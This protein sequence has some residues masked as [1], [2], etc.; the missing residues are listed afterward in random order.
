LTPSLEP[1]SPEAMQTVIP[2]RR[3]LEGLIHRRHG[4]RSPIRF[5]AAQLMEITERLVVV[6]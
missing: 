2:K 5:R 1:L 6:S 4:L 3:G